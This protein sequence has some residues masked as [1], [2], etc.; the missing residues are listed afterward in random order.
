MGLCSM[1]GLVWRISIAGVLGLTPQH[2]PS[3][4]PVVLHNSQGPVGGLSIQISSIL[5]RPSVLG[6]LS[7]YIFLLLL[8]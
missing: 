4:E 8:M 6:I 1:G 3:W 2:V 7:F 5:Y